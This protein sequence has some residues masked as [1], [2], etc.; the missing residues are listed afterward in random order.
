MVL[1]LSLKLSILL[2][3]KLYSR[4]VLGILSSAKINSGKKRLAFLK[5]NSHENYTRLGNPTYS[6][7]AF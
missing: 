7:K 4:E 1:K 5:I 2:N 3:T 6:Y